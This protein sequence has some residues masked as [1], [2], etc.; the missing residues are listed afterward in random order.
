M[1]STIFNNH[2]MYYVTPRYNSIKK[3]IKRKSF[4]NN[5]FFETL[6]VN[7][8]STTRVHSTTDESS[9]RER[10]M[11][12]ENIVPVTVNTGRKFAEGCPGARDDATVV[13]YTARQNTSITPARAN[14][15][16]RESTSEQSIKIGFSAALFTSGVS[17]RR[18][19]CWISWLFQ[20]L[21]SWLMERHHWLC[22]QLPAG[23]R[24]V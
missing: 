4:P 24:R 10:V 3:D 13:K 6:P 14:E 11:A 12:I 2:M 9:P 23:Y 21:V 16:N 22:C 8:W 19:L 18:P 20:L 17:A 1:C 15:Q 5:S 7:L